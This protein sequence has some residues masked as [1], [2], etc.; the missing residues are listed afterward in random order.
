[1]TLH[2]HQAIGAVG[3]GLMILLDDTSSLYAPV[4]QVVLSQIAHNIYSAIREIFPLITGLGFGSLFPMPLVAL[5]AA[6][7]VKDMATSTATLGLM[8][9]ATF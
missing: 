1:M 4:A 5:H 9:Y 7:S 2:V 6:M 3:N 8:R